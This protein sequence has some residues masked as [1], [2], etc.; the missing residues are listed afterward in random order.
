MK[1]RPA[2]SPAPGHALCRGTPPGTGRR[3]RSARRRSTW[4]WSCQRHHPRRAA[5][6]R[7]ASRPPAAATARSP[8]GRRIET[9][10]ASERCAE[11]HGTPCCGL[12]V[13]PCGAMRLPPPLAVQ[14]APA[15][16]AVRTGNQR[17]GRVTAPRRPRACQRRV[18]LSISAYDGVNMSTPPG[19]AWQIASIAA[20]TL[21]WKSNWGPRGCTRGQGVRRA[22]VGGWAQAPAWSARR[23]RRAASNAASRPGVHGIQGRVRPLAARREWHACWQVAG[24]D[25]RQRAPCPPPCRFL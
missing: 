3:A 21:S 8:G 5:R 9:K 17:R 16:R 12:P 6:Q 4:R 2:R 18:S 11:P 15:A 20:P 10:Q 25:P 13:K 23:R 7:Q 24:S 19:T 22:W 14:R 1:R